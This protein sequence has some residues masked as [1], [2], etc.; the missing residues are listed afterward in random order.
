MYASSWDVSIDTVYPQRGS[1]Q[2]PGLFSGREHHGFSF[3]PR[4][5]L[6]PDPCFKGKLMLLFFLFSSKFGNVGE[7]CSGYAD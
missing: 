1:N 7:I 4:F 3:N 2:N 5:W 6:E